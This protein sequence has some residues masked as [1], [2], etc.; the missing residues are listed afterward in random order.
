MNYLNGIITHHHGIMTHQN[1]T[2]ILKLHIQMTTEQ[3]PKRGRPHKKTEDRQT[4][5]ISFWLTD[6]D[7]THILT[8]AHGNNLT[9]SGYIRTLI[10]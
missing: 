9:V 10:V 5:N 7:Y 2:S 3:K 6:N 4:R 8:K 1:G